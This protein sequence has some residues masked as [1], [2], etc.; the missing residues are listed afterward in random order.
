VTIRLVQFLAIIL[1]AVY[2]VPGGA[3]VFELP[4]KIGMDQ[5]SYM[6]AQR[7]YDGWFRFN[8]FLIAAMVAAAVLASLSRRQRPPYGFAIAGLVLMLAS[9]GGFFVFVRPI[10][11]ATAGWTVVPEDFEA[12]RAQWEYGHVFDAALIFLALVALVISALAW[13]PPAS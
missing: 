11:L 3:H 8:L 13:K 5:S 6:T 7:L 10:N 1:V 2:L 9:A 4:N 12:A